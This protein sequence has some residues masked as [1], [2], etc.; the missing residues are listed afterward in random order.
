MRYAKDDGTL[1]QQLLF[2]RVC[3]P[4]TLTAVHHHRRSSQQPRSAEHVDYTAAIAAFRVRSN[5]PSHARMH[6]RG[7]QAM[8]AAPAYRQQK[9]PRTPAPVPERY[10]R[11]VVVDV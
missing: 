10:V 4:V 11:S 6:R 5:I 7:K 2:R 1:R 3:L 8:A 9:V